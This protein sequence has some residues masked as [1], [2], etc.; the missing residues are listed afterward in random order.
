MTTEQQNLNLRTTSFEL[1]YDG[2]KT[3][4][5]VIDA[6]VLG[7]SLM[8]FSAMVKEANELLN[9]PN[10]EISI[11]VKAYKEGSFE[12]WFAIAQMGGQLNVAEVLGLATGGAVTGGLIAVVNKLKGRKVTD[13]II[14]ERT[15][16]LKIDGET[17]E[18]TKEINTLLQS[19]PIR[20]DLSK[21]FHQP[22][23]RDVKAKL[24]T[25]NKQQE[26]LEVGFEQVNYFRDQQV[27]KTITTIEPDKQYIRIA[28]INFA[29]SQSGWK[30]ILPNEETPVAVKINDEKFWKQVK[31]NTARF[32]SDDLFYV[33]LEI[34]T[35]DNGIEQKKT[36]AIK[37][38]IEHSPADG[39][40]KVV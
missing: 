27:T 25:G 10:S 17:I 21:I 11:E 29:S 35:V 15:Q 19:N 24:Y 39:K 38:V 18:S 5:H 1:V 14:D 37:Q 34:K 12:T 8:A 36:Y 40:N 13:V 22:I 31:E 28:T 6:D 2:G 4:D 33:E 20:K 26:L 16:S 23:S 3:E 30:V 7:R 9:G 32:S